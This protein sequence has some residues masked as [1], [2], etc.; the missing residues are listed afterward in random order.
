LES[1]YALANPSEWIEKLRPDVVLLSVVAGD[2]E[3]RSSP[4]TPEAVES[5]T[6]LR[7]DRDG[8]IE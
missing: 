4:E 3:G 5:Y 6:L 1:S 7:T 2:R 8:W